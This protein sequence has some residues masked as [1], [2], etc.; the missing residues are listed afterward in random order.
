VA[1]DRGGE[2]A[3]QA[4]GVARPFPYASLRGPAV[5]LE[6]DNYSG[7]R[8]LGAAVLARQADRHAARARHE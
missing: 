3:G 6:A 5:V 4:L 1:L 8:A 7:R 2:E